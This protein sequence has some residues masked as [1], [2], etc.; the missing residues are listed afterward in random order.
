MAVL[1]RATERLELMGRTR[2]VAIVGM[3]A[4]TARASHFVATY[5][6]EKTDWTLHYVNPTLDEVLGQPCYPDLASLPEV[7]DIVDV[8]RRTEELPGVTDEAIAI[9]A[10]SVWFQLGLVHDEAAAT[11]SGAGLEVVQDKCLKIE[12]ARFCGGLHDAGFVTN[13]IDSRKRALI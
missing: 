6:L 4:N 8:F 13:V 3:S 7:P 12:H 5:L 1:E 9:G 11:A 10:A 2:S